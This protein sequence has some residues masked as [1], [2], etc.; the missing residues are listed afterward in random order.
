MGVK[1]IAKG[2]LDVVTMGAVSRREQEGAR[3]D[4]RRAQQKREAEELQK[5]KEAA[6]RKP[7]EEKATLD[8]LATGREG[9]IGK[10]ELLVEPTS[11]KKTA[12]GTAGSTGL[13][14]NV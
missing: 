7:D 6:E 11:K 2:A 10:G 3:D 5:R 14:F 9:A 8:L 13:G 1:D 4:A 12:L